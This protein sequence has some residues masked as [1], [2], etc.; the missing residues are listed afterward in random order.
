MLFIDR[1]I[2]GQN[3]VSIPTISDAEYE[4]NRNYGD[5]R[6]KECQ[7]LVK[8]AIGNRQ[9][10]V[11]RRNMEE[12]LSREAMDYIGGRD[13][14]AVFNLIMMIGCASFVESQYRFSTP[15]FRKTLTADVILDKCRILKLNNQEIVNVLN[16]CGYKEEAEQ[17]VG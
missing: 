4:E 10:T 15:A 6:I 1:D 3:E 12:Y 14:K 5:C 8:A 2:F 11:L 13:W 16:R 17:I 9:A 7:A